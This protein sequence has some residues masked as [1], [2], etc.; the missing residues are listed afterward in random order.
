[1]GFTTQAHLQVELLRVMLCPACN[2]ADFLE[3]FN[4]E[5]AVCKMLFRCGCS[6]FCSHGAGCSKGGLLPEK[7]N[8]AH[9]WLEAGLGKN[10]SNVGGSLCFPERPFCEEMR[11][12]PAAQAA[13][14]AL[15]GTD[16]TSSQWRGH[17]FLFLWWHGKLEQGSWEAHVNGK[18]IE[19]EL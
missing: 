1:M 2:Q 4:L 13:T 16:C 17:H 6:E 12:R 3:D 9:V 10:R 15:L 14:L 18:I 5:W 7:G 11:S 8:M 19:N